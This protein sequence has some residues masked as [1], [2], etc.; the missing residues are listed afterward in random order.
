[1]RERPES[2]E[3]HVWVSSFR[4]NGRRRDVWRKLLSPDEAERADR[5]RFERDR[6]RYVTSRGMLRLLL[7][8]YTGILPERLRFRYG[9]NGKPALVSSTG[10]NLI[11]FNLSHAGDWFVLAVSS[12]REVGVDVE[13][14]REFPDADSVV[15]RFF[16]PAETGRYL[17]LKEEKGW[18]AFFICWTRREAYLKATGEG[19]TGEMD[20]SRVWIAGEEE[21]PDKTKPWTVVDLVLGEE[22]AAALCAEGRGWVPVIRRFP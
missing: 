6:D 11:R 13:P 21:E 5:F 9:T 17:R 12:D 22:V 15:E 4:A 16:T 10:G 14:V 19:L 20:E 8:E 18:A 7:A 1:M 3:I 2:G